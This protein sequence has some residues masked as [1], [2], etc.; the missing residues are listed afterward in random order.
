MLKDNIYQIFSVVSNAR[1]KEIEKNSSKIK[2]FNQIKKEISLPFDNDFFGKISRN[3][4]DLKKAKNTFLIDSQKLNHSLFWFVN[5]NAIDKIALENIKK[6]DTDKAHE[7]WANQVGKSKINSKNFSFYSNL[8]T[9]LLF[10]KDYLKA[11]DYKFQLFESP[12]FMDFTNL[13]LGENHNTSKNDAIDFFVKNLINN[14]LETNYK[15]LEIIKL[16]SKSKDEF[17]DTITEYFIKKPIS[18]INKLINNLKSDIKQ[19]TSENS[20]EFKVSKSNLVRLLGREIT[21]D[22]TSTSS[23]NSVFEVIIE[24]KSKLETRHIEKLLANS[25]KKISVSKKN[26]NN[27][28]AGIV[29]RELMNKTKDDIKFLENILSKD[30]SEYVLIADKI[31]KQLEQCGVTYYNSSGS[32][33]DY[34]DVYE[35]A[36]AIAKEENTIKKLKEAIKH[37]KNDKLNVGVDDVVG[38]IKRFQNIENPNLE[39]ATYLLD[40]C[41][42]LLEIIEQNRGSND[43]LYLNLT[44]AVLKNVMSV[45]IE[46]ENRRIALENKEYYY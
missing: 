43:E 36:L 1:L 23:S 30:N 28:R 39:D 9:L 25:I 40:D 46:I 13:I 42:P 5:A 21:K 3:D 22:V 14:L 38:F 44:G 37:S 16:F 7:I 18:N 10:E 45:S 6:G 32:D 20:E 26:F 29:G 17:K 15:P 4:R 2:A 35:Y 19:L 24:S 8:S 34:I 31:A 27:K 41:E 33:L 11:F 12:F